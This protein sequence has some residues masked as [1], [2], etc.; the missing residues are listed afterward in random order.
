ME[1]TLGGESVLSGA[2]RSRLL[3]ELPLAYKHLTDTD[4]TLFAQSMGVKDANA[5]REIVAYFNQPRIK[6]DLRQAKRLLTICL[7]DTEDGNVDAETVRKVFG[8]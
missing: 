3:F 6:R 8:L 1:E 7:R 4:L 2:V 5:L